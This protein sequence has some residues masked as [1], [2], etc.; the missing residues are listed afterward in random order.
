V[1]Y[2][3]RQFKKLFAAEATNKIVPQ[4]AAISPSTQVA[5]RDG[6]DC[7]GRNGRDA[8]T[9]KIRQTCV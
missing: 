5:A 4:A 6:D 1:F 3:V 9:I 7:N 8:I 2:S